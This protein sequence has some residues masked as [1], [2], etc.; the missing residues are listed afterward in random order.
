MIKKIT[1]LLIEIIYKIHTYL[2]TLNDNLAISFSD[3]ELH[4]LIFGILGIL[5]IILLYPLFKWF[6]KK[7]LLILIVWL[8]VFTI[9][10][11]VAFA[12][13]IAQ[14][15]SGSGTMEFKDIVAGLVGYFIMSFIF[16]L[17]IK[18]LKGLKKK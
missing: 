11:V 18:I 16:I 2:L 4:F 10:V 14:W 5:M 3:K 6:V 13:E 12:I 9:L 15:Y 1:D 8:Y 7:K 17:I